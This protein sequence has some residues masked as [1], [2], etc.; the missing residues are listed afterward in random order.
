LNSAKRQRILDGI[1]E[2]VGSGGYD[3][4]PVSAVLERAGVHRH[5]FYASFGSKQECFELAYAQGLARLERTVVGA[6]RAAPDWRG[7]L[8]AG[9]CALLGF[10]DAEPTVGRALIVEVHSGGDAA[11]AERDAALR[12]AA[13]FLAEGREAAREAADSP[14]APAIAPEAIA[15]GIHQLLHSRLAAGESG[16]FAALLPELMFVA[17]LPYY[18][19]D[20]AREEMRA[21]TP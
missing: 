11:Q 18:G 20:A 12:R 21:S 1:L 15:S 3:G 14:P 9:L 8:R 6:A 16:G 7:R 4:T 19:P 5:A 10:L 17:V 13:A 2:A